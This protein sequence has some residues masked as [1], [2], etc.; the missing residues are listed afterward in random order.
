MWYFVGVAVLFIIL[1]CLVNVNE[2]NNRLKE[3]L[4]QRNEKYNELKNELE[5][6]NKIIEGLNND[7]NSKSN[8]IKELNLNI[9]NLIKELSNYTEIKS[10]SLKLNIN[11]VEVQKNEIQEVPS[12]KLN[13]QSGIVIDTSLCYEK[14]EIYDLME[15]TNMNLFITGKAGTG[16]SYLLKYFRSNTNKRVLYTAPTGIAALNI[17]AVTLHSAFGFTNLMDDRAIKLSSDRLTVLRLIDTLVI[18][19]ISMVRVDVFNQINKILQ[20][21]N[22]NKMPFGG[23]QII[24]F[25]DLFQLPPVANKEEMEFFTQ[26]YGGIYFFNSPVYKIANFKFKELQQV[27]R[28]TDEKFIKVLNNIREGLVDEDDINFMNSR[29]TAELPRR[30]VQVVPTKN[31]ANYINTNSLLKINGKE[32]IYKALILSGED[33]IKESDFSCSFEL[34]LKVGALVMM[35]VND[36]EHKRWVNGTLGIISKLSDDSIV[37]T[38]NGIDYEISCVTFSKYKC[39]YDINEQKIKYIE[40]ASVKQYPLVLAYAITI[41]KSQ[42]MTYQQVAC[43]LKQCFAPGQAYVALSRCANFDGLYLTEKLNSN[44]IITDNIVTNFY[45]NVKMQ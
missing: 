41:H 18:D 42:G 15:N 14:K 17:N 5:K 19:E 9:D 36:Q 22:K 37:V 1:V 35:I 31:Q 11:E 34:N 6:S 8:L 32:Y 4:V 39:E 29:Y 25:G 26:K 20:Y 3:E 40:E 38:I 2:T 7:I 28:Q 27:F 44:S 30:V 43:D 33:K 13:I 16:K 10:D 23:K 24:L 12:D 21:A 45:K